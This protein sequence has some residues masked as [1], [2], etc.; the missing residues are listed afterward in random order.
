MRPGRS[1]ALARYALANN[2]RTPYTWV[3]G[4]LFIALAG[5]GLYSSARRGHGWTVDP[6]LLFDAG[7]IAAVFGVRSGL[8]AQRDTGLETFLRVNFVTP[9]EHMA[10]A[11][12]SLVASWLC[13]C[14]AVFLFSWLLPGGSM[15]AAAWTT[16]LFA[17]RT[18]VLLPFVI[19]AE[20]VTSI[21]IPFFLPGF[22]YFGLLITLVFVL[23]EVEALV[24]LAPPMTRGD[25]S[26]ALPAAIRLAAV[27]PTGFVA[28]L[29]AVRW[30]ARK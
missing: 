30:R 16:T 15:E 25:W 19:M 26:S 1:M 11:I 7:L 20:S 8:V 3:G 2:T 10:G 4:M 28:V 18:G 12:A 24:L 5:L 14:T 13:V 17:L 21:E 6:S 29:L 27:L 22:A 9:V 23:G